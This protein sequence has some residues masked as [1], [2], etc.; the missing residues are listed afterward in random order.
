MPI[1]IY[2]KYRPKTL[3]DLNGQELIVEIIKGA[4]RADKIG[5]A[6]LLYGPRGTGK[7]SAARII[8]KL[9]NC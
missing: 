8:A 7:T 5:H 6:N 9:A 2:R 1:A 3:G 4:A